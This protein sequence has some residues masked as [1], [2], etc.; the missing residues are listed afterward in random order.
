MAHALALF[1]LASATVLEPKMDRFRAPRLG[2]N[3][4]AHAGD[5]VLPFLSRA[6]GLLRERALLVLRQHSI[7]GLH[8]E[9]VDSPAPVRSRQTVF[10]PICR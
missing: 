9:L 5:V 8:L 7:L 3:E 1:V 4:D 10:L 2:V 6:V